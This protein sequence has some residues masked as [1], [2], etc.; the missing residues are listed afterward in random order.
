VTAYPSHRKADRAL[1]D[2]GERVLVEMATDELRGWRL[3][4]RP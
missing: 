1:P 2:I 3:L 4:R